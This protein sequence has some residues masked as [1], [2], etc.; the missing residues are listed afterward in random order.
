M[1][2]ST[3]TKQIDWIISLVP[4]ASVILLCVLFFLYPQSSNTILSAIRNYIGDSFGLYY[5]LIGLGFFLFSLY[6]AL[7][8]YGKIVLGDPLDKPKYSFFAWGSMMFTCGLAADILFYSPSEW[9]F[10]ANESY[11]HQLGDPFTWASVFPLFH[12]SF[13]P[14]SFYLCLAIAFGF[15]LHVRKRS[16]QKYS[17][18]C[19]PLLGK[20]TDGILGRLIDLFA[21]FALLAGTATTFSIATPLLSTILTEIF[22]LSINKT[23]VTIIIL[24]LTCVVY[25]STLLFEFK[26]IKFLA[27]ACIFLFFSLIAYV[28]FLGGKTTFILETGFTAIGTMLQNFVSLASYTDASRSTLFPQ[29][30]T[31]YFWAYWM[32]WCV[33]VPFF[34]GNISKGR[35]IKQVIFGGY[36]FGV[37]STLLSFISFGNYGLSLQVFGEIDLLGSFTA[38]GDIYNSILQIF[39]SLPFPTL[40]QILLIA[41]IIAF[42]ATSFDS[43]A[44]TATWY[45]Y[46]R[47]STEEETSKFMRLL[48]CILLILL[49]TALVFSESSM[50]SLQSLSII[51]AFPLGFIMLLILFSFI[52][53]AKSYL[54]GTETKK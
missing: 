34:I 2:N 16:R 36:L 37:G 13:I 42:Y 28:L 1:K 9:L 49:P 54:Q 14:W 12:W 17:E 39:Q 10:Y 11:I 41:L 26:G 52:K 30:W 46:H 8:K 27:K 19:R 51:A 44:L 43:I 18:A 31:I 50:N 33:A 23:S 40:V 3:K 6:L 45:S 47:I 22:H 48:W 4:L 7:S 20:H 53:D 35:T 29:N 21:V 15:M 38:H 25:T 5:L 24:L 32:V